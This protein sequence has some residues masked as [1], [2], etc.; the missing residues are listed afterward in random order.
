M[1]S[2]IY[3]VISHDFLIL[4]LLTLDSEFNSE[5]EKLIFFSP[6]FLSPN[7]PNDK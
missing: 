7:L 6:Q 2:T 1:N 5:R 4:V 3:R